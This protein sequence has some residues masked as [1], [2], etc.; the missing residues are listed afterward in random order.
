M[1][2]TKRPAKE[3]GIY[4]ISLRPEVN[5]EEFEKFMSEEVLVTTGP[6]RDGQSARDE[7]YARRGGGEENSYLWIISRTPSMAGRG[8]S[9]SSDASAAFKT[10]KGKVESHGEVFPL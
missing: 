4:K 6:F 10:L 5:A 7:L 1:A 3:F 9:A 2:K 8:F